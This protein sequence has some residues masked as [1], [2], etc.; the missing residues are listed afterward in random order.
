MARAGQAAPM[1]RVLAVLLAVLAGCTAS[2]PSESEPPSTAAPAGAPERAAPAGPSAPRA[3]SDHDGDGIPT[4][5]EIQLGLDAFK[6]DTD[7]DGASDGDEV[8]VLRT[9]PKAADT[10]LDGLC[11]GAERAAGLDPLDPDTDGDGYLDGEEGRW[12]ERAP[13]FAAPACSDPATPPWMARLDPRGLDLVV[14]PFVMDG[15]SVPAGWEDFLRQRLRQMP[16][17]LNVTFLGPSSIAP[18]PL[19]FPPLPDGFGPPVENIVFVQALE[20]DA[21]AE[22]YGWAN[23]PG[24]LAVVA[25]GRI[26]QQEGA[27]ADRVLREVLMHEVGHNLGLRHVQ[28][29]VQPAP[30]T[31]MWS[32]VNEHTTDDLTAEEWGQAAG[33]FQANR[34]RTLRPA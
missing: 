22:T 17:A 10:D 16:L 25:A 12:R 34:Q 23:T 31:A 30:R 28:G 26:A 6:A 24:F 8:R 33:Q 13:G 3:P 9:R 19:G 2:L 29:G 32:S 14:K 18:R 5:E 20:A 11:D 4:D 7:D 27:D 15:V 21:T 1:R